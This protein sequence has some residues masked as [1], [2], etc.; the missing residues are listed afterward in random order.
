MCE[1]EHSE[2]VFLGGWGGGGEREREK[3]S[4]LDEQDLAPLVRVRVQPVSTSAAQAPT[5]H[6]LILYEK[7]IEF[8]LFWH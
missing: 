3:E 2:I 1:R 8:K 5:V 6:T 4:M 7:E